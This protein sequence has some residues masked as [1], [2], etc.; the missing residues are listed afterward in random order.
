[1]STQRDDQNAREDAEEIQV[2]DAEASAG[3]DAL[4]LED[5]DLS[6]ET[7]EE[8]ISPSETNVFDK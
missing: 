7:V 1:M 4:D 2:N 5:L 8:R 3:D 6:V